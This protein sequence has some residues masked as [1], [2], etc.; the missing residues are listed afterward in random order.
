MFMAVG[1]VQ[2]HSRIFFTDCPKLRI[3]V[4]TDGKTSRTDFVK[5]GQL[6]RKL[7]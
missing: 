3:E 2:R 1:L 7:N 6:I 4:E 5:I